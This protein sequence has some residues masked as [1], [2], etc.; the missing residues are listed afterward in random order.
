DANSTGFLLDDAPG[1]ALR[2]AGRFASLPVRF[3]TEPPERA[4]APAMVGAAAFALAVFLPLRR[5]ELLFWSVWFLACTLPLALLDLARQTRH[6][7][8][9]RYAILAAPA[10]Y[11]LVAASLSN[12]P[13]FLRHAPPMVAALA[14]LLALPGAYD[15]WWKPDWRMLARGLDRQARPGDVTVFYRGLDWW[16][17]GNAFLHTSYYRSTPQGPI[18]LL[19]EPPHDAAVRALRDA[20]GVLIV[21]PGAGGVEDLL[22]GAQLEGLQFE[23][24][25]A[26]MWRATWPDAPAVTTTT[27]KPTIAPVG[28]N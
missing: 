8:F 15:G 21:E 4:L 6:L 12:R 18:M 1:H 13:G 11:A 28:G 14:C 7:E 22:P 3:F 24:G 23:P 17:P 27:S 19:D 5:R 9:V 25:I 16:A 20:P 10:L 2:A 26:R